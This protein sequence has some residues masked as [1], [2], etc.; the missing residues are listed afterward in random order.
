MVAAL[1]HVGLEII[2]E[3]TRIVVVVVVIAAPAVVV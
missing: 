2:L 1:F 3:Y